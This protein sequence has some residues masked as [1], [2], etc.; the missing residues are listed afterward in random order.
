LKSGSLESEA[1]GQWN[2]INLFHDQDKRGKNFVAIRLY[3][4][5]NLLE[6]ATASARA[7]IR[8]DPRDRPYPLWEPL[9]TIPNFS[10]AANFRPRNDV[11]IEIISMIAKICFEQTQNYQGSR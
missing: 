11:R 3:C 2:V 5:G 6:G 10:I 8:R 7:K 1:R 9:C 4:K